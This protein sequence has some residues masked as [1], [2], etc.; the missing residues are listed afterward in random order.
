MYIFTQ[1][2]YWEVGWPLQETY[3]VKM[4]VLWGVPPCSLGGRPDDGGSKYLWNVGKLL[5]DC[6]AE[7]YRRRPSSNTNY[8][9]VK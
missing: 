6:T 5:P 4:A 7:R 1:Y 2:F 9:G 8:F 3:C